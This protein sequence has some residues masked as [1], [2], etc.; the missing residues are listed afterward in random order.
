MKRIALLLVAMMVV[1]MVS[2]QQHIEFKWHGFYVVAG[3]DYAT[4]LNNTS[5]NDK[6]AFSGVTAIG[7]FQIRK[8]SGIGLGCSYMRDATG[9]FSQLPVFVELRSHYL[10]SRLTPY[11]AVYAGYSIPL[12]S[13]SGG[14]EAIQIA[15]GGM[16]L[17]VNLGVRY[18]VT[19]KFGVNAYAGYQALHMNRVDRKIGGERANAEPLLLHN[20]KFGVGLNF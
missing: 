17:G 3:Y 8:E 5:Y 20:L 1:G 12:G 10:R 9:A 16:T 19:R 18:A 6:V 2:A 14:D 7:G 11:S 15:S 4:N 13:S